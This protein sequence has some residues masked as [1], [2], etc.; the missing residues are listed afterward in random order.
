MNRLLLLLFVLGLGFAGCHS[1]PSEAEE[2]AAWATDT[3]WWVPYRLADI[4]FRARPFLPGEA[5]GTLPGDDLS[6][7]SGLAASRVNPGYLWSVED[8]G[9]AG[10]I[11]LL[12]P[13]GTIVG[14][15]R[16]EGIGNRDWE[17]LA[18][19][20]GPVPGQSYLYL[21]D[22]GDNGLR[23]PEKRIYRFPEP[24]L[25][26]RPQPV[27]ERISRIETIRLTLPDGPK[28]S[29]AFL[30]DPLSGDLY[31]FSKEA[32][33]VAYRARSP[34]PTD[35]PVSMNRIMAMPF[36]KLTAA[37]ISP[38]GDEIL[39]R[40]YTQLFYFKRKPGQTVRQALWLKPVKV[41]VA[42]EPQGEAVAWA[43]DGS[44]Y[45]TLSEKPNSPPQ[46]LYFY[47]RRNLSPPAVLP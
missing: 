32:R 7:A 31:L 24:R 37:S 39:L 26:D 14:H 27:R 3:L 30:V 20:P 16:L 23:H 11:Q 40:T 35:R 41:A 1:R 17:E 25:A 45:F 29:E 46:H 18:I 42:D 36:H 33:T 47:Q 19:G 15:Y 10:E 38:S 34:L 9:N 13:N 21:G 22:I 12:H 28:N 44:G 8:S 6:E 2:G 4:P 5:V 43:L